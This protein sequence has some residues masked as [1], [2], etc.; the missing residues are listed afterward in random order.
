MKTLC[1]LITSVVLAM[2][3]I[4][5]APVSAQKTVL[6]LGT[7]APD[8]TNWW[9][10]LD[11]MAQRW[12]AESNERVELHVLA[13]GTQGD[14]GKMLDRVKL[15]HLQVVALSGAGLAAVVPG[16]NALQLP[17]LVDSYAGLDRIRAGLE[18]RL[19]KAFDEK[20][21]IVLNWSDVGWVHFFTKKEARTPSALK[22]MKLFIMAGDLETERLYRDMG[23]TPV[24]VPLT[25]MLTSLKTGMIDAFDLP[26]L[27]AIGNQ[28]VGLVSYM[29]DLKWAPVIGAT[30]IDKKSW[31]TIPPELRDKL[32]RIA[33]QTGEELRADIRSQED[34][35]TKNMASRGLTIVKPTAAELEEWRKT[36]QAAQQR[37]RGG[38]V[39]VDYFDEAVRLAGPAPASTR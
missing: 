3:L 22:P 14:E 34:K 11:R 23:F 20:G 27:F 18:P 28:S 7:A 37:L 32:L 16:V 29:V 2:L 36:A 10:V 33:R 35:A 25:N 12:K 31:Q 21:Y 17:M 38:L 8:G 13:G 15:G 24:P 19:E 39:P 9:K 30:I 5:P 6:K 4:W 1:R 26:P